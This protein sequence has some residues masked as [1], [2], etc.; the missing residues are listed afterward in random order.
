MHSLN[1]YILAPIAFLAPVQAL[2]YSDMQVEPAPT[3]L[4]TTDDTQSSIKQ[5]RTKCPKCQESGR[6]QISRALPTWVSLKGLLVRKVEFQ[7][8]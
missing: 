7:N 4:E 1:R 8:K 3:F 2:E 6:I 5:M